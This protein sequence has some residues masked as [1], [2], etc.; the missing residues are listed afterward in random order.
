M[1]GSLVVLISTKLLKFSRVLCS[2]RMVG[3][4]SF[5]PPPAYWTRCCKQDEGPSPVAVLFAISA[6]A[7]P[8]ILSSH[9]NS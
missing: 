4:R 5:L 2:H 6:L 1:Q 8:K 9:R 3:E 7:F